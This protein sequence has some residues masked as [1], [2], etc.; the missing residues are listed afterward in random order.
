MYMKNKHQNLRTSLFIFAIV[1][2]YSC[3]NESIVQQENK[4]FTLDFTEVNIGELHNQ[5]MIK[6]YSKIKKN[7]NVDIKNMQSMPRKVL[8]KQLAEI[9][10]DEYS[11]IQYDPTPIGYS[12]DQFMEKAVLLVDSLSSVQYDIR[13]FSDDYLN[14]T[15]TEIAYQ[16]VERMINTVESNNNLQDIYNEI[17]K[18]ERDANEKLRGNDL[19]IVIGTI[20]IARSSAYLWAPENQRGYD[21]YSKTFGTLAPEKITSIEWKPIRLNWWQ[22]ALIGDMSASAQYFIGIGVAGAL[23][24][25]AP[26]SNVVVLG[27]WA[28][29]A[30]MGS[31]FAAVGI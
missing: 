8:Q 5:Y 2:I 28:V 1:F 9:I 23:G 20:A 15:T 7:F 14:S 6:S 18:I 29:A 13:N 31:A 27:G 4:C 12:H 10:I 11:N 22:R 26:G 21:L 3:S 19:A 25:A 16:Y 30:G 17:D 24:A